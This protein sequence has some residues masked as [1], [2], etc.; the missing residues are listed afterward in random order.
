MKIMPFESQKTVAM[1]FPAHGTVFA[2]SGACLP[3]EVHYFD[4]SFISGMQ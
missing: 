4:S 2:F 3:G 1:T